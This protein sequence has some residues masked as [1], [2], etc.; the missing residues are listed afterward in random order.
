MWFLKLTNGFT[1]FPTYLLIA[2]LLQFNC[3]LLL[4]V[5]LLQDPKQKEDELT[6]TNVKCGFVYQIPHLGDVEHA[7]AS[8]YPIDAAKVPSYIQSCLLLLD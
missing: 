6:N 5:T 4:M 2:T 3:Y 1:Q 8:H 7:S